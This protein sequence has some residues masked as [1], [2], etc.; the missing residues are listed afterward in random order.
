MSSLDEEIGAVQVVEE[1]DGD[2][3]GDGKQQSN[4]H[5]DGANIGTDGQRAPGMTRVS[6]SLDESRES[7]H[8]RLTS[9][10]THGNGSGTRRGDS[11]KT[12]AE[13]AKSSGVANSETDSA[14]AG[15]NDD[16]DVPELPRAQLGAFDL[17]YQH[18]DAPVEAAF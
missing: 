15:T 1:E 5:G 6:E 16:I 7:A 2:S 13:P 3:D 10:I 18:D 4:D 14:T 17:R 11:T 9:E 12:S 8:G